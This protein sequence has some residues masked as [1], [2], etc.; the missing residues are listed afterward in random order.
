MLQVCLPEITK[1]I[2]TWN[3]SI[4]EDFEIFWPLSEIRI[5]IQIE[6]MRRKGCSIETRFMS[7]SWMSENCHPKGCAERKIRWQ[8]SQDLSLLA[9]KSALWLE[10]S[11]TGMTGKFESIKIRA[12]DGFKSGGK[13]PLDH[14]RKQPQDD[15]EWSVSTVLWDFV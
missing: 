7:L 2:W 10:G 9:L 5:Q 4:F 15:L 11:A 3:V 1:P 8:K 6:T 13:F 14:P 12:M